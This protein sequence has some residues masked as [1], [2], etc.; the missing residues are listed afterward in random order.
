[1]DME[2]FI[3][4]SSQSRGTGNRLDDPGRSTNRE[5][6]T[7]V[8]SDFVSFGNLDFHQQMDF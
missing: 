8:N 2:Q 4:S 3:D 6:D 5:S 7:R 1:M